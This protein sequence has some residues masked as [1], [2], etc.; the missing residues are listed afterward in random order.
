M[1]PPRQHRGGYQGDG[2][3]IEESAEDGGGDDGRGGKRQQDE[4]EVYE[5]GGALDES[6]WQ[7]SPTKNLS[8]ENSGIDGRGGPDA[9]VVHMIYQLHQAQ[10][11][12]RPGALR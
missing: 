5:P 2:D 3:I 6:A 12:R 8:R 11:N 7:T 9:G 1:H 4:E 10:L